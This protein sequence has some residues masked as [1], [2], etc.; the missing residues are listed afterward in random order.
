MNSLV[1]GNP[2]VQ[3]A[4]FTV[5]L[6]ALWFNAL[7][8]SLDLADFAGE[9]NFIERWKDEVNKSSIGFLE[10]FWTNDHDHLADVVSNGIA[11]WSVRP[12]MVI[13]AAMDYSPL[14]TEQK[15][16]ILSV[17]KRKLLTNRGL[18]TL[19]PD[20]LRFKGLVEGNQNERETAIHQGAVHPWLIQFFVEAYLR[21]HKR[22]GLPFVKQI[23][24]S[25]EDE[26]TEHCVGTVSEMYN[27][28]PPHRA[29]GA[30]SQAWNV[31]GVFYA[32]KLVEEYNE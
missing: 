1:D 31:A 11:D 3:R 20:H 26:L 19:S 2:V 8:F 7:C 5:E 22:G 13:A 14:N 30:I 28:T 12:N 18:R 21:I 10:T 16:S 24:E 9:K 27:G 6:N 4:G 29:K 23:M 32:T 17:T 15:K 25:F